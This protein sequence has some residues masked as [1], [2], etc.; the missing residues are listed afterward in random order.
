ME[1]W[2]NSCHY[3]SV[4]HPLDSIHEVL[5]REV[6]VHAT[7]IVH[8]WYENTLTFTINIHRDTFKVNQGKQNVTKSLLHTISYFQPVSIVKVTLLMYFFLPKVALFCF[9]K[10]FITIYITTH[11]KAQSFAIWALW[12]K[13]WMVIYELSGSGFKYRCSQFNS[14]IAP[15]SQSVDHTE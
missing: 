8:L 9:I 4:S 11:N 1:P 14:D 15:V 5:R 6:I 10:C 7:F 3:T 12:I 13:V 2:E